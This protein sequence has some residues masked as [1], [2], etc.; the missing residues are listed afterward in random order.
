ML[1]LPAH[2][3]LTP[4]ILLDEDTAFGARLLE[5][6]S[7]K[8]AELLGIQREN[9]CKSLF[10]LFIPPEIRKFTPLLPALRALERVCARTQGDYPIV[11]A[12]CV[13][14][15][16]YVLTVVSIVRNCHL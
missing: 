15:L 11:G 6:Q 13:R 1:A 5:D 9:V 3:V 7:V 16:P 12:V 2:H 8:G 14:T 10:Y 4:T